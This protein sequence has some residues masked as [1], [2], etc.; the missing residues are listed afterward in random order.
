VDGE[1]DDSVYLRDYRAYV[2][3]LSGPPAELIGPAASGLTAA[4]NIAAIYQALFPATRFETAGSPG[5]NWVEVEIRRNTNVISWLMEGT[6]IAQRSN[7][8]SFSTGT[9]ML[10]L[11]DVFNSIASP[12]ADSFVLF[13]NVRVE[14]LSDRIRFLGVSREDDGQVQLELSAVPGRSYLVESSMDLVTWQPLATAQCINAPL[15]FV[16]AEAAFEPRRF[17]RARQTGGP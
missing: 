5:K 14:D 1:G 12:A 16:D 4:D 10:G 11:M 6:L 15:R 17:Y 3:N 13:D 2:G 7:Q 9:I 8:L